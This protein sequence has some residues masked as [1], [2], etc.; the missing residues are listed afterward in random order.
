MIGFDYTAETVAENVA[1]DEWL[2]THCA[3]EQ[4]PMT[5][6]CW[7]PNHVGVV[8]GYGNR[9]DKEVNQLACDMDGVPIIRR[10][11]GGGAVVVGPGCLCY[12]L[13]GSI[14]NQSEWATIHGVTN[15]VM[16]HMQRMLHDV[17]GL[18]VD[19]RGTSDLVINGL[20][21]SGNAQRR[22]R[23]AVL[24]HGTFLCQFNLETV[25]R[26]L[27]HPSREPAYRDGRPHHLFVSNLQV[28]P[29][30]L[31][32]G[33]MAWFGATEDGQFAIPVMK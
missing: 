27:H 33:M 4:W 12:A 5:L 25:S 26:Y 3:T 32:K 18:Q 31:K 7:I 22:I 10:C 20:K 2:L 8:V 19:C 24:F 6:R 28:D 14:C 21:I 17:L 13:V 15:W 11:S 9:I 16:G 29:F 30:Q 23:N 1:V